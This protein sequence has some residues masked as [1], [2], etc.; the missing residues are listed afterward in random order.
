MSR[1]RGRTGWRRCASRPRAA[2]AHRGRAAPDRR[3]ARRRHTG[4]RTLSPAQQATVSHAAAIIGSAGNENGQ[5][6]G[7][8]RL[9]DRLL[10]IIDDLTGV[11]AD[12]DADC[13]CELTGG[14]L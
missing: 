12:A 14:G 2:T 1:R 13:G 11:D 3:S 10:M 7:Y 4:S 6:A 9:L 5:L 8:A